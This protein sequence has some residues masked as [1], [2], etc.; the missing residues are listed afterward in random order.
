MDLLFPAHRSVESS[1]TVRGLGATIDAIPLAIECGGGTLSDLGILHSYLQLPQLRP[2][3]LRSWP[4]DQ[5]RL[6]HSGSDHWEF[7]R[8]GHNLRLDGQVGQLIFT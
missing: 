2:N 6:P 4:S 8:S 5:K 3:S 1:P 7:W